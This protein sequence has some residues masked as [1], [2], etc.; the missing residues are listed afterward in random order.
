LTRQLLTFSRR[1]RVNPEA[2]SI[3]Q[4]ITS[5]REVLTSGLGGSIGL[6]F[7][8]APDVWPVTVDVGEFE[9]ALVNLVINARDAMPDGGT[10]TVRASNAA[11]REGGILAPGDYVAVSVKD[12]GIGIPPDILVHVFDPFFTTKPVGK[13]TGLGLSQVHGFVHQAGGTVTID[14]EL[15]KGT[16]F[17]MYLPRAARSSADAVADAVEA[18]KARTGTVLLVEDNP[19]VASASSGL[20]EQLGYQ[21]RW[22]PNAETALLEIEKSAIDLVFSD[23]V[24]PGRLDGL[25]LAHTI[26]QKYPSLPILLATGY[27]E[28]TRNAHAN[29]SILRKPYQMQELSSALAQLIRG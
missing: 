23:I 1:Q 26:R 18:M 7:D 12:T 24:M 19:D 3:R 5:I 2:I 11:M 8:F 21:V 22:A 16:T 17:T 13:G 10:V 14:S 28:A 9:I 20:L 4:H 27:S 29:F 15:G 25:G 6:A